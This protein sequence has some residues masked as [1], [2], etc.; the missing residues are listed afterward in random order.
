MSDILTREEFEDS[1]R[2]VAAFAAIRPDAAN[3]EQ[4]I[5]AN[6]RIV[7]AKRALCDTYDAMVTRI[8]ELEA[9]SDDTANQ[10]RGIVQGHPQASTLTPSGMAAVTWQM[11]TG[12][13][14]GRKKDAERIA[15][16]EEALAEFGERYIESWNWARPSQPAFDGGAWYCSHCF[17]HADE[18]KDVEHTEGCLVTIVEALLPKEGANGQGH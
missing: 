5:R 9:L 14:M 7:H 13:A 17:A 10:L 3:L 1:I 2:D 12:M 15:E 11:Y 6:S 16:L 18:L 4:R 8:A